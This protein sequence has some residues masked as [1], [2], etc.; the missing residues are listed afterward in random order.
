MINKRN[1]KPRLHY[2]TGCFSGGRNPSKISKFH[3]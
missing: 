1:L 2:T 3:H